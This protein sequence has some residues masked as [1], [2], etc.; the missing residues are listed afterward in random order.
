MQINNHSS[1]VTVRIAIA[2]VNRPPKKVGKRT[3]SQ[4]QRTVMSP[5]PTLLLASQFST[6]NFSNMSY[7]H[8]HRIYPLQMDCLHLSG[9]C[10]CT[11]KSEAQAQ[12]QDNHELHFFTLNNQDCL[13]YFFTYT[14]FC[15]SVQC[16]IGK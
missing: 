14:Y 15:Y 13:K 2:Y 3:A 8:T 7:T 11:P 16:T 6:P 9:N 4:C 12:N 5:V 10:N 1:T